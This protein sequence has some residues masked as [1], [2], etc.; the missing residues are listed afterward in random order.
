M[1]YQRSRSRSLG[2]QLGRYQRKDG[3]KETATEVA[4]AI[5]VL[6]IEEEERRTEDVNFALIGHLISLLT[7]GK[8]VERDCM[9]VFVESILIDIVFQ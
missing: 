6:I 3:D 8:F 2:Y 9:C 7:I 4:V 1:R 5:V